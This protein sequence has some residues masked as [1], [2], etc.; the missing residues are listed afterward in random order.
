MTMMMYTC[1]HRTHK[2]V[3]VDDVD[4]L[5][6]DSHIDG[7]INLSGQQTA[8]GVFHFPTEECTTKQH[9]PT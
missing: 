2:V 5:G 1:E 8:A 3:T 6:V 4:S 7:I 9:H